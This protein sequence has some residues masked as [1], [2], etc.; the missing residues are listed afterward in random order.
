MRTVRIQFD[1]SE[2]SDSVARRIVFA[3]NP[4]N[5]FKVRDSFFKVTGLRSVHGVTPESVTGDYAQILPPNPNAS[6][7]EVKKERLDAIG[8]AHERVKARASSIPPPMSETPISEPPPSGVQPMVQ[9]GQTWKPRDPR[10]K[11]SF[12]VAKIDEDF[13]Y[14]ED[15]RKVARERLKR[16]EMVG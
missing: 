2:P 6:L 4:G 7:D 16:Y 13:V 1:D 15:G 11:A 5:V 14:A 9:V 3:F 8:Q 12:T 10:R